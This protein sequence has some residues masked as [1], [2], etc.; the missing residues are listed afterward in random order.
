MVEKGLVH[1][2]YSK[3]GSMSSTSR[4]SKSKT[5]ADQEMDLE[6]TGAKGRG[7]MTHMEIW[8]GPRNSIGDM[9]GRYRRLDSVV[10]IAPDIRKESEKEGQG[11]RELW[12]L[13]VKLLLR[14]RDKA[15]E[16]GRI[17]R[18]L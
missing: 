16:V 7:T 12:V 5:T 2:T 11:C 17:S 10:S 8:S 1:Y 6:M 13:L 4:L 3:S 18:V 14:S 9:N 15:N